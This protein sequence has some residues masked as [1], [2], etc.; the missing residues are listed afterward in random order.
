MMLGGMCQGFNGI[1]HPPSPT[2]NTGE[3]TGHHDGSFIPP[4]FCG[5]HM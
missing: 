4:I 5:T 3:S 1:V 2:F